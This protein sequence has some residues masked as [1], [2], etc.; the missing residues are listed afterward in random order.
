MKTNDEMMDM[1]N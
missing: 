1:S